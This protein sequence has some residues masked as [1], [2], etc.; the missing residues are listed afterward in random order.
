MCNTNCWKELWI[1]FTYIYRNAHI[2][3]SNHPSYYWKY[4]AW[5]FLCTIELSHS[6]CMVNHGTWTYSP[7]TLSVILSSQDEHYPLM[8][9]CVYIRYFISRSS[10]SWC[11]Q[12]VVTQGGLLAVYVTSYEI[13]AGYAQRCMASRHTAVT[14]Q[15]WPISS[16]IFRY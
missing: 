4:L 5:I 16:A 15:Q 11:T 13:V 14:P 12:R 10:V 2:V 9:R 6:K 8:Y 3:I 7:D 1:M